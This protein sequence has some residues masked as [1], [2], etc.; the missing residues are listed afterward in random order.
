M[1]YVKLK[2]KPLLR[3]AAGEQYVYFKL[4]RFSA[5]GTRSGSAYRNNQPRYLS[6]L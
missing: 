2:L 4:D 1:L 5:C 3:K 6:G